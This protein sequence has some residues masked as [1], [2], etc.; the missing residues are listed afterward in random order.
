MNVMIKKIE[1]DMTKKIW[2]KHSLTVGELI[3]TVLGVILILFGTKL[4]LKNKIAKPLGIAL[5]FIG[6][7]L[8]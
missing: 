6:E 5:I 3:F 1:R 4:G 8:F 7:A 2:G